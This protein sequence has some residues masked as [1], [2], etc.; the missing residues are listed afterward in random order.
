MNKNNSRHRIFFRIILITL[1]TFVF[2]I[3]LDSINFFQK[4]EN[5]FYDY[6]IKKTASLLPPSEEIA[7]VFL[8]D[9]YLDRL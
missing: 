7:V 1:G 3:A 5:V 2:T 9:K 8:S 6:R 4:A